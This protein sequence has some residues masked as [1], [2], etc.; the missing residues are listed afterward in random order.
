VSGN[1]VHYLVVIAELAQSLAV[2]F[3]FTE[4]NITQR[5]FGQRL[6]E[7]WSLELCNHIIFSAVRGY[8]KKAAI[9]IGKRAHQIFH[10]QNAR[11]NRSAFFHLKGTY[12]AA[13]V[14]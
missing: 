14:V 11:V 4:R 6:L 1:L 9:V 2:S 13:L 3:Q 5:H 7:G 12:N 10:T 8:K